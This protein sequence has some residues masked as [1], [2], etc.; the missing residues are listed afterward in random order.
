MLMKSSPECDYETYKI[1]SGPNKRPKTSH[2]WTPIDLTKYTKA[3][4]S[5]QYREQTVNYSMTAIGA[6]SVAQLGFTSKPLFEISKLLRVATGG[7]K[8]SNK[9]QRQNRLSNR[10]LVTVEE[11]NQND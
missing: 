4:L 8:K 9:G 6:P 5:E 3:M 2:L 1:V 7:V 11:E 10:A